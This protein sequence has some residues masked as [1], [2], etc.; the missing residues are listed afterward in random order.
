MVPL[1]INGKFHRIVA[2]PAMMYGSEYWAL[3]KRDEIQT[4]LTEIRILK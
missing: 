3:N 4:E 1:K 2:R